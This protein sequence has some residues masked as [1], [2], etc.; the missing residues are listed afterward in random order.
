M[1]D[2]THPNHYAQMDTNYGEYAHWTSF[3]CI[4]MGTY[5]IFFCKYFSAVQIFYLK[6]I[7]YGNWLWCL[8]Q[9]LNKIFQKTKVIVNYHILVTHNWSGHS[10]INF[11]SNW[12]MFAWCS[13]CYMKWITIPNTL[14][15]KSMYISL[16]FW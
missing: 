4:Q 10:F 13:T 5:L 14:F 12:Q 1:L 8:I 6:S 3:L 7:Q 16:I 9:W 11:H 2:C 15:K